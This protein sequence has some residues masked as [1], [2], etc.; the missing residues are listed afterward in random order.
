MNMK[1]VNLIQKQEAP[2]NSTTRTRNL[3]K[4][5]IETY[6]KKRH[7]KLSNEKTQRKHVTTPA[8]GL[9]PVLY[10]QCP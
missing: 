7:G 5:I 3:Q 1:Q 2:I 8:A 6:I 9:E 4:Q 10:Y